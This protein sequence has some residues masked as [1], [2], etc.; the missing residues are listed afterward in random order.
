MTERRRRFRP[1]IA[2]TLASLAGILLLLALGFWQIQRLH[3]K[4]ALIA[5]AKAGMRAVPVELRSG[6]S[7]P[8]A[9]DFHRVVVKGRL[10]ED[11]SFLYGTHAVE[12]E[13]GGYLVTP[14]QLPDGAVLLVDRGWLAEGAL[15]KRQPDARGGRTVARIEG[16]ARSLRERRPGWFTPANAPDRR[17][18]YWFDL[19]A[20]GRLV[21][22]PVEP[23]LVVAQRAEPQEVLARV[24]RVRIDFP[25]RHLGYAITWFGL[26][27]SLFVVYLLFGFREQSSAA[28]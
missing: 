23:L 26:A 25:N 10:L 14:L 7:D 1:G 2:A 21:G 9:L 12:G 28:D 3:W 13:V 16:V 18:F 5:A 17:R 6:V 27:V 20:I 8:G 22:R 19:D 4:E 24:H 15:A 11:R